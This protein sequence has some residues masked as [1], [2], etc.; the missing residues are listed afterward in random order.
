MAKKRRCSELR[1]LAVEE[2]RFRSI[3]GDTAAGEGEREGRV[4]RRYPAKKKGRGS[5]CGAHHVPSKDR[6]HQ[7]GPGESGS[8]DP[9]EPDPD[10][11]DEWLPSGSSDT[12]TASSPERE[13]DRSDNGRDRGKN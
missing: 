13:P 7:H 1:Q 5:G 11:S 8:E 4:G 2:S 3:S 10:T 12:N 6:G 9:S